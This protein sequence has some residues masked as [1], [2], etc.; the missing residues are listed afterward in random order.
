MSYA[1]WRIQQ[2]RYARIETD[3][4]NK[5]T[6]GKDSYSRTRDETVAL[7][8]NYHVGI[9][10]KYKEAPHQETDRARSWL[11]FKIANRPKRKRTRTDSLSVSIVGRTT[12]GHTSARNCPTK[13]RPNY[14]RPATRAEGRKGAHTSG[15]VHR[16]VRFRQQGCHF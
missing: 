6:F 11:S 15:P 1:E 3:P 10:V 13:R 4:E 8:N 7:L 2:T 9:N 14:K 16:W 5:M 12:I